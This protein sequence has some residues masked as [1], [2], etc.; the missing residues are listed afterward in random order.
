VASAFLLLLLLQIPCTYI[1]FIRLQ[2]RQCTFS[3]FGN[4]TIHCNEQSG[5][6]LL[7]ILSLP[8]PLPFL[9]RQVKLKVPR[10]RV[11]PPPRRNPENPK[12]LQSPIHIP[13]PSLQNINAKNALPGL[14]RTTW[15]CKSSTSI[16]SF[17]MNSQRGAYLQSQCGMSQTE[18]ESIAAEAGLDLVEYPPT[19][20]GHVL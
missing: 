14:D 5:A 2:N 15:L 6:S 19:V 10:V 16:A 12:F 4:I 8:L 20:R 9:H 13:P 17:G 11:R 7:Q 18:T 3:P 1:S